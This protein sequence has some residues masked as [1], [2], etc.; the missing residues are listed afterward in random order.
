MMNENLWFVV[1]MWLVCSGVWLFE[2]IKYRKEV[3]DA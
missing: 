1:F 2:Y 3:K